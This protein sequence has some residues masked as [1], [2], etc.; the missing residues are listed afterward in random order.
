MTSFDRAAAVEAAAS[1]SAAFYSR[2]S[3]G[4][5]I[6]R[7]TAAYWIAAAAA[8]RYFHCTVIRLSG[9]LA[10]S[11]QIW[12][13]PLDMSRIS[14]SFSYVRDVDQWSGYFFNENWMSRIRQQMKIDRER[15]REGGEREN[16][17][18]FIFLVFEVCIPLG[19]EWSFIYCTYVDRFFMKV[20]SSAGWA[21]S[22]TSQKL[23]VCLCVN[24]GVTNHNRCTSCMRSR[25]PRTIPSHFL[26]H[27]SAQFVS[28]I[29]ERHIPLAACSISCYL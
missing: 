26:G 28:L 25:H 23:Y 29:D 6:S 27:F 1:L 11:V 15:G 19:A 18:E 13:A 7:I 24:Q 9:V 3:H 2:I 16:V 12:R 20:F 5:W 22:I 4:P 10:H 21:N 8:A 14:Q 17:N